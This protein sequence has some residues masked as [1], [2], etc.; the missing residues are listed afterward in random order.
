MDKLQ[1]E[2]REFVRELGVDFFGVAALTPARDFILAQGGL[3]IATF[4]KAISLGTRLLDAVIDELFRHEQPS[5]LYTYLGLYNSV[6]ANLDR[7]ALLVAKKIQKAG[8]IPVAFGGQNWQE[9]TVFES[10]VAGIGGADFYRKTMVD[11]DPNYLN[12]PTM[13]KCFKQLKDGVQYPG[14]RPK[15]MV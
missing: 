8:F 7:S 14:T 12:S 15:S 6:N 4:P 11:A 9:S 5:A 2:F 10:I 13:V 3:H 1:E